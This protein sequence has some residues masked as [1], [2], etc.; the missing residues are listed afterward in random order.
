MTVSAGEIS[1]FFGAGASAPFEIPTMRH[2]TKLF[3]ERLR[4]EG[5]QEETGVYDRIVKEL[6]KDL[7]KEEVDIETIFSV[8]NGLRKYSATDISPVSLYVSRVL[9]GESL[10]DE[11]IRLKTSDLQILN[12]LET[13]F[14][15]FVR[16]CCVLKENSGDKIVNVYTS[17][18]RNLHDE[19]GLNPIPSAESALKFKYDYNWTFFTT[20][21]DRCIEFFWD[22]ALLDTRGRLVRG[23]VDQDRFLDPDWFLKNFG[24]KYLSAPGELRLVK[25]HG[26]TSWLVRKDNGKI[27]DKEYTFDQARRYIGTGSV[28]TDEIVIYPLF[29]K[30]MYLAPYIQLF[31]CL[32]K[33]L[34]YRNVWLVIGYSFRDPVIKNI[35]AT[36]LANTSKKMIVVG[37]NADE[38]VRREFANHNDKIRSIN[39]RFGESNYEDVNRNIAQ[40]L[41]SL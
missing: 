29:E 36:N 32:A 7:G 38:D 2:M 18:F 35:F 11:R 23:F 30:E 9:F 21:Y 28:Y 6:E 5:S 40:E 34:A 25:L 22:S 10:L 16:E 19:G 20:N 4:S 14:K 33:E 17:F 8:V 1:F 3:N 41:K 39:A 27:E 12:S 26:S 24:N 37:P 15:Y 13:H 31:Y